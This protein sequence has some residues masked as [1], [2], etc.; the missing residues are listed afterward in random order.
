MVAETKNDIMSLTRRL[1]RLI[2]LLLGKKWRNGGVLWKLQTDLLAL[3]HDIQKEISYRKSFAQ[4]ADG[5]EVLREL[6]QL[7]WNAR[8]FGD[9]IAWLFLGM[10][11]QFID[12]LAENKRVPIAESVDHGLRGMLALCQVASE[13]G[14]GFPLLHDIT[15]SLRIG[16][17]TF[18]KPGNDFATIEV[19][20]KL[21]EETRSPDV[22]HF[23][24]EVT[25][26][27]PAVEGIDQRI[28]SVVTT[29]TREGVPMPPRL[30]VERQL[31]RMSRA[32]KLQDTPL[33]SL[34][35]FDE[36]PPLLTASFVAPRSDQFTTFA[37][38]LRRARRFGYASGS[39]DNGIFYT[40]FY[41]PDGEPREI[42]DKSSFR[43]D[44][45]TSGFM[46]PS[47]E[48]VNTA[49]MF[50][51]PTM[52]SP[53]RASLYMPMYLYS[54]PRAS[55]IDLING[56]LVAVIAVN[57]GFVAD[58]LERA[59]FTI[60]DDSGR[61]DIQ[62]GKVRVFRRVNIPE[63]GPVNMEITGLWYYL[64][65]MVYDFHSTRFFVDMANKIVKN[66]A[67]IMLDKRRAHI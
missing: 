2:H 14:W 46:R 64:E 50:T 47:G 21:I 32:R 25:A 58:A 27:A 4:R 56:R 3:Q 23:Q 6:Q 42:I 44:L 24:Y 26:L 12:P 1:E 57:M 40:A 9:A 8:R 19:K 37:R 52:Q 65:E 18:I 66:L 28:K 45:K 15:D 51:L 53:Q 34:I 7:R 30:R 48:G 55:I 31:K 36:E 49:H 13:Q 61:L 22:A 16:D 67:Q 41:S 29:A 60:R 11:R 10:N 63:I 35:E 5:R 17:I 39:A 62:D 43:D 20:T 54:I 59:G 33:D 38:V